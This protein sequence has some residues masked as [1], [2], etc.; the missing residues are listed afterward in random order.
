MRRATSVVLA[1]PPGS[2]VL[3]PQVCYWGFRDWL[4][5]E[6]PLVRL[7]GHLVDMGKRGRGAR[8]RAAG[9]QAHLDRTPSNPLWASPTSQRSPR[10]RTRQAPRS[11]STPRRRRRVHPARGRS[12]DIV[13]HSATKYLNGHSM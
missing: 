6:A 11:R 8:R 7:Q 10:S 9:H 5:N 2:H 13:M 1:L 12:A 3:G 4:I